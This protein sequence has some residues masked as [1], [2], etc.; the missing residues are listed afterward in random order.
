MNVI[1]AWNPAQNPAQTP[2]ARSLLLRRSLLGNAMF[3]TL[4]GLVSLLA[5]APLAKTLGIP[6]PTFLAVLGSQLLVFAGFLVWL[7]TRTAP[8]PGLVWTVIVLDIVW[9]AGSVALLPFVADF[10]TDLGLVSMGLTALVVASFAVGQ[11]L[12]VKRIEP[13]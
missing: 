9:V 7:A 2:A 12:G 6:D 10:M 3:S 11:T 4:T 5:A 13:A 8:Q 1:N